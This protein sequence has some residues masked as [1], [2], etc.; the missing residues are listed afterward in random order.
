MLRSVVMNAWNGVNVEAVVERR[1]VR[2]VGCGPVSPV[3]SS[4]DCRSGSCDRFNRQLHPEE[5]TLAKQLAEKRMGKY[6]QAQIEEQM[7]IMGVSTFENGHGSG[8]PDTLVGQAPIDS[9]AKWIY[10][11]S[12]ADGKPILTQVA[13]L[14]NPELQQYIIAN[15]NTAT[16]DQVPSQFTYDRPSSNGWDST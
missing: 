15:A 12:T 8:A 4:R 10:A 6:T 2:R 1:I 16:A 11:G 3:R 5:K 14:A 13:A 7:R 9:G